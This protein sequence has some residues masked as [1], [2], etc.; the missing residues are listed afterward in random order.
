MAAAPGAARNLAAPAPPR[1][2]PAPPRRSALF[3]L[4]HA[5]LLE[6]GVRRGAGRRGGHDRRDGHDAR[7]AAARQAR[8]VVARRERRREQT[9]VAEMKSGVAAEEQAAGRLRECWW[10]SYWIPPELMTLRLCM[11]HNLQPSYALSHRTSESAAVSC[12]CARSFGSTSILALASTCKAYA[13]GLRAEVLR[14]TALVPAKQYG[15]R[16][17]CPGGHPVSA[18][19]ARYIA[20]ARVWVEGRDV[21]DVEAHMYVLLRETQSRGAVHVHGVAWPIDTS[22]EEVD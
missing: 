3:D 22:M 17:G 6:A 5:K 18:S 2:A 14:A 16:H 11:P 19:V 1:T 20:R 10:D 15:C 13:H 7:G 12:G 8:S 9:K 21:T 4:D